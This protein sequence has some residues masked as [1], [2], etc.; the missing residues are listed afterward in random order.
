MSPDLLRQG[1]LEVFVRFDTDNDGVMSCDELNSLR[2]ALHSPAPPLTSI[3]F[4]SMC[5]NHSLQRTDHGLTLEGFIDMYQLTPRAAIAD[6]N[7]LGITLGPLLFPRQALM[8]AS[9]RIIKAQG[10]LKE[11]EKR[12]I[13]LRKE[14]ETVTTKLHV[15]EQ[16]LM[17]AKN[18]AEQARQQVYTY[19]ENQ[20]QMHTVL[21]N[22]KIRLLSSDQNSQVL[23]AQLAKLRRGI[24]DMNVQ[25]I[26]KI[27]EKEHFQRQCWAITEESYVANAMTRA[28]KASATKAIAEKTDLMRKNN[29]LHTTLKSRQLSYGRVNS[30]QTDDW[31]KSQPKIHFSRRKQKKSM[32]EK[33]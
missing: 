32:Q 29:I 1:L 26:K 9:R 28:A 2:A 17:Q 15:V 8:E 12:N 4:T 11:R 25:L 5:D 31:P 3:A 16:K 6:L 10:V 24:A 23:Q 21:E 13:L 14:C 18:E 19:A 30:T 7:T 27:E 20:K 33:V 22:Q